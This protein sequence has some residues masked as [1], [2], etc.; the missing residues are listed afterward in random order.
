MMLVT[1]DEENIG[2]RRLHDEAR[3]DR[4]ARRGL[5]LGIWFAAGILKPEITSTNQIIR[6]FDCS[7]NQNFSNLISD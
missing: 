5:E 7:H 3:T 4:N 2:A 1:R 6:P